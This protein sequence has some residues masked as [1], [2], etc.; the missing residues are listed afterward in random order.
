MTIIRT[1]Q[2]TNKSSFSRSLKQILKALGGATVSIGATF[3][4]LTFSAQADDYR[5]LLETDKG[6]VYIDWSG[7]DANLD[8]VIDANELFGNF[9]VSFSGATYDLGSPSSWT[10]TSFSYDVSDSLL[11]LSHYGIDVGRYDVFDSGITLSS[12]VYGP[13]DPDGPYALHYQE[14]VYERYDD[15]LDRTFY[16]TTDFYF[17]YDS[18]TNQSTQRRVVTS[19]GGGG[20]VS[21]ASTP[22]PTLTLGFI[23]LGGLML[24]SKRKRKA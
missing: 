24:G 8:G 6:N 5:T 10:L 17:Y 19:G 15:L 12:Y 22:E 11:D 1:S 18:P 13:E 14:Y 9:T 2:P 3:S 21:L 23:T 4:L 20:G 16:T 7:S